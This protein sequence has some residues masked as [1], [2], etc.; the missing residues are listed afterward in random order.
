M[1]WRRV[2]VPVVSLPPAQGDTAGAVRPSMP[3]YLKLTISFCAEAPG[4]GFAL[5][6]CGMTGMLIAELGV[7]SGW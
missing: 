7:S 5:L 2:W 3:T 4:A 1:L 6:A